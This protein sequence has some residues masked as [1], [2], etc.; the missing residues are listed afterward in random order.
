[1]TVKDLI[2]YTIIVNNRSSIYFDQYT[3]QLKIKS[4]TC[5]FTLRKSLA[6]YFIKTNG[7]YFSLTYI[8]RY[9][10]S[11]TFLEDKL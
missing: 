6:D 4:K 9:S 1:M 7:K 5:S 11:K 3:F 8:D 2:R 10:E